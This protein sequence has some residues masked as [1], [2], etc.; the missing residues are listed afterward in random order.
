MFE[1]IWEERGLVRRFIGHVTAEELA[2]SA[3][4]DQQDPRF[5]TMR[6]V[7]NDFRAC[8]SVNA[9]PEAIEEIAATDAG[10]ART[11]D[12]IHIATVSD[13][14]DVLAITDM[15]QKAGYSPYPTQNF[16]T[17]EAARAWLSENAHR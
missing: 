16:N 6:Y 8:T 14:P 9:P 10:A 17:M 2:N 5:D 3:I 13:D 11:N 15:Y 4:L 7:I 12:T 1:H